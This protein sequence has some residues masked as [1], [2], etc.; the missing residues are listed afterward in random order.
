MNRAAGGGGDV[1]LL[2]HFRGRVVRS[3][4]PA[5]EADTATLMDFDVSQ[6]HGLHFVYVLPFDAHTALVES[7]F[8]TERLLPE[9]VYEEAIDAWLARRRTGAVFET[10]SRE[11]GVIPMTPSCGRCC[12]GRL[13]RTRC[14]ASTPTRWARRPQR[15][16]PV[17]CKSTKADP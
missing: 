8:F 7:T 15:S 16:P 1:H 10:V 12:L 13:S 9:A 17:C 4:E 3:A 11:G 6:A 5:F 14:P 2:Q